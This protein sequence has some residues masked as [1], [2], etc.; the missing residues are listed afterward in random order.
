MVTNHTLVI[1]N[2]LILWEFEPSGD[3]DP[4]AQEQSGRTPQRG[5]L[6]R[7]A[8]PCSA[9]F[10]DLF[11]FTAHPRPSHTSLLSLWETAQEERP[12][13]PDYS[14]LPHTECT[15]W[16]ETAWFLLELRERCSQ[17]SF[18]TI[19][20]LVLSATQASQPCQPPGG[21]PE[22]AE[23]SPGVRVLRPHSASRAG[24]IPARV[25]GHPLPQKWTKQS[26]QGFMRESSHGD[27]FVRLCKKPC[28]VK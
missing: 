2:Y 15:P 1:A 3:S 7:A 10:S 25:S 8:V 14:L 23:A 12:G 27:F 16:R 20:P 26:S 17:L 4:G 19:L 18:T 9:V 6:T 5:H 11:A 22:E 21:L 24:Q 28:V 13:D